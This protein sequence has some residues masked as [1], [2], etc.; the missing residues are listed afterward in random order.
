M[1]IKI[2]TYIEILDQI[3]GSEFIVIDN[4]L[5]EL[6]P[7]IKNILLE[8]KVYIVKEAETSKSLLEYEKIMSFFLRNVIQRDD[9][10]LAI[11][12]GAV[13]DL[14]GF[15]AATILRG[16]RW[17]VIP[18]TLLSMIDASIGGK[19]G[20][21]TDLGKNLVGSLHLPEENFLCWNFLETLPEVE[22]LSGKGE[23]IKYSYLSKDIHE[24]VLARGSLFD[25]IN[26]CGAF[27][28]KAV[29]KDFKESGKRKTLNFGH[30]LGHC[31]ERSLDISHG[32]AVYY[33]IEM[34]MSLYGKRDETIWSNI[35][36][37]LE[38]NAP[39][40]GKMNFSVFKKYLKQDK[41]R[42]AH[43]SIE[44]VLVQEVGV[45]YFKIKDIN[46]L[47]EDIKKHEIYENYFE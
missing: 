15:V 28:Q 29:E 19:V 18:T 31:I 44:L 8:K 12:G 41:K 22:L 1:F 3:K 26:M 32:I 46:E 30:T 11:G 10:I 35:N 14:A 6:Y 40:I 7:E 25:V 27:K 13:S 42:V 37:S 45:P 24:A 4:I 38:F 17:R 43:N 2:K 36:T 5:L 16:V 23:L 21:N 20:V 39:R 33:G 9:F 47:I 34:I